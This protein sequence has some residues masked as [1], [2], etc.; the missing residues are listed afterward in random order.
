MRLSFAFALAAAGL[1]MPAAATKVLVPKSDAPIAETRRY[2]TTDPDAPTLGP[3]TA[4]VTVVIYT[5]YQCP[6]CRKGAPAL[7]ELAKRDPKVQILFRDWPIFGK[8]SVNAA[9]FAIG[10]KYQG[11]YVPFHMALMKEPRPLSAER[12]RA[13]A[14]KAGVDWARLNADMKTH[15][16][17]IIDLVMRNHEQGEILD[18]TGT[19]GYLIGN[20]QHFGEMSL[21]SLLETVREARAKAKGLPTTVRKSRKKS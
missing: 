1:A 18:F 10:S 19:P 7:L 2:F 14:T 11:K 17:D 9:R 15:Q 3:K 16:D 13:A 12:I 5:D 8:E 4:D 20:F 6:Y 21:Q